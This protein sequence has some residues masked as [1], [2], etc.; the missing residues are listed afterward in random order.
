MRIFIVGDST[1]AKKRD[2]KRPETGWGEAL[3]VCLGGSVE[4]LNFAENGRSSRSFIDEGT[5]DRVSERIGRG[6][7]LLIQFG[8][9][10]EKDDPARHTDPATSFPDCLRQ[11]IRVAREA[12][13]LPYL[14]TPV[15]RRSYGPDG[16]SV[17]THG[18]YPDAIRAL[19]SAE[20]VPL[21]DITT[22]SQRLLDRMGVDESRNLF[23]HLEVGEDPIYPGGLADDTHLSPTGACAIAVFVADALRVSLHF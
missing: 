22:L 9:N 10:D 15:A 8:H 4:V 5:L 16:N 11:Y 12:D 6:D 19:A 2:D 13:A 3:D 1:A 7:I 20:R 18:A 14:L 21:I 23:L 17:N